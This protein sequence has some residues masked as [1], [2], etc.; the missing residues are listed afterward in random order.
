MWLLLAFTYWLAVA[1]LGQLPYIGPGLSMVLLPAFTMSFMALCAVLDAGAPFSAAVLAQPFRTRF[2]DLAILGALYLVSIVIV[3]AVA[4]LADDGS[5]L[6]WALAGREPSQDAIAEGSPSRA[7]LVTA[8]AG[9][10][11]ALAFWFAPPLVAWAGMGAAQSLFYSFFAALRNWRAFLVYFAV[12]ML[13]G[14]AMLSAL[15]TIAVV[16]R[17]R[18]DAVRSVLLLFTIFSMPIL[19]GSFYASYREVFPAAGP[20]SARPGAE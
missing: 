20:S 16:T 11:V 14:V 5:L 10:P 9:V 3:L 7:L 17:G 12:L 6:G 4:S 13:A 18:A 8:V 2:R 15:A 1:L 19:F